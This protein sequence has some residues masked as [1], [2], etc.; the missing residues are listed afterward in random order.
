M[1]D[2]QKAEAYRNAIDQIEQQEFGKETELR[3]LAAQKAQLLADLAEV[4]NN[5]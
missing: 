5:D 3:M 4:D 1:N 2:E